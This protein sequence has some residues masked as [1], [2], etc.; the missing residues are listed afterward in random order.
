MILPEQFL[1]WLFTRIMFTLGMVP[2]V[3]FLNCSQNCSGTQTHLHS[4]ACH[5]SEITSMQSILG[6]HRSGRNC[7][8]ALVKKTTISPRFL[9]YA[10]DVR[11]ICICSQK[12]S[13][14]ESEQL[15]QISQPVCSQNTPLRPIPFTFACRTVLD[16]LEQSQSIIWTWQ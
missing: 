6:M 16:C 3:P 1:V 13:Q 14:S 15:E 4:T 12:C 2:T 5:I 7:T 10:R 8:Y 11:E 9:L